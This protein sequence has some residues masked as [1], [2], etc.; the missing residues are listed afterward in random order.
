MKICIT[1]LLLFCYQ[2]AF[3]QEDFVFAEMG[4]Q[5]VA[6]NILQKK[7]SQRRNRF[8]AFYYNSTK[9]I[10]EESEGDDPFGN[11][12]TT[13]IE[14]NRLAGY[15]SMPRDEMRA[16][17]TRLKLLQQQEQRKSQWQYFILLLTQTGAPFLYLNK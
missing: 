14:M 7:T 15:I 17:L 6:K 4:N 8:T 16:K 3:C 12:A 1:F 9:K 11:E 5:Y 10:T 13:S 2:A